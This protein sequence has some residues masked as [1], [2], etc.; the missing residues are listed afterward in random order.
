MAS[1]RDTSRGTVLLRG[2]RGEGVRFSRKAQMKLDQL[3]PLIAPPD[4]DFTGQIGRRRR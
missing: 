3:M 1:D 4:L 2:R